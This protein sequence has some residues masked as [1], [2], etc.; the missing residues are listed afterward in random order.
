MPGDPGTPGSPTINKLQ[1]SE[2]LSEYLFNVDIDTFGQVSY[3]MA[4]IIPFE[5]GGPT[6]P[7]G[8]WGPGKP[9]GP[10][11]PIGPSGPGKPGWK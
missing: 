6:G 3:N 8:P 2:Y 9:S 10:G 11:G 1:N 7:G 4:F 5:P